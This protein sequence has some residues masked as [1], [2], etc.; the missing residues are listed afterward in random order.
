MTQRLKSFQ[1]ILQDLYKGN[2]KGHL[3]NIDIITSEIIIMN[4]SINYEQ[5]KIILDKLSSYEIYR[6]R[7]FNLYRITHFS[8]SES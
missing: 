4:E 7:D 3:K 2:Y 1:N 5:V 6:E 8:S